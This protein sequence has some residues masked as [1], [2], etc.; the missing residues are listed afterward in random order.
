MTLENMRQNGPRAVAAYCLDCHHNAVVNV[1][2]LPGSVT[3]PSLAHRLRC[4]R[5][6]GRRVDVRPAWHT[7]PAKPAP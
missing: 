3:V 5:C 2:H 6:E 4:S 1:D 7:V